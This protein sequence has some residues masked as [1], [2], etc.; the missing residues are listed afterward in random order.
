MPTRSLSP[1]LRP[2]GP[3]TYTKMKVEYPPDRH[4]S[5][6][7]VR[8]SI[9]HCF[10]VTANLKSYGLYTSCCYEII[11]LKLIIAKKK[12]N[13]ILTEKNGLSILNFIRR[14]L[15]SY[16]LLPYIHCPK[17]VENWEVRLCWLLLFCTSS[18]TF[19]DEGVSLISN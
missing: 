3:H 17:N 7:D 9:Q 6:S 12:T 8:T 10:D 2:F 19:K 1:H 18:S 4:P 5:K 15:I 13:Q 16:S 11:R 14:S